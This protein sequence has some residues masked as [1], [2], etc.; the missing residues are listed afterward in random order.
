MDSSFRQ[1]VGRCLSEKSGKPLEVQRLVPVSGGSIHSAFR[2]DLSDG[3]Q[4]FVKGGS[5]VSLEVFERE[6]EGLS[7]LAEPGILRVPKVLLSAKEAGKSF[8]ALEW[9]ETGRKGPNFFETFGRDLARFHRRT[10]EEA[11]HGGR[12]G[13]SQD[14]WLGSTPQPNRWENDWTEFWRRHRLGHQ[15]QLARHDGHSDPQLE[16]LGNR[17]ADRL[18]EWTDVPEEPP[19]L[20]HGDLCGGNYL[21]DESGQAVLIDPATYYGHREADLAMTRLFG[22]FAPAFYSAYEEEWPLPPGSAERLAI[23]ELYH[24]LNH[25]HLFGTSYRD[26]CLGIL[27]RLVGRK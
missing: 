6:A 20:L 19:C 21:V 17:L 8:L 1:A 16:K 15:L 7:A 4:A 12:F 3:R 24:L 25:L 27:E 18:E 2:A 5:E 10:A 26:S 22:G 13:F 23:Y 9:V 14:N 11:T